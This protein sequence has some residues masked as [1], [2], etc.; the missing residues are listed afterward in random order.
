MDEIINPPTLDAGLKHAL[1]E[2]ISI[3][4]NRPIWVR[5][6]PISSTS[7][8][9]VGVRVGT[10]TPS[11]EENQ[12]I[13][14]A[15]MQDAPDAVTEF[16]KAAITLVNISIPPDVI[17]IFISTPTPVTMMMVFQGTEWNAVFSSIT[18]A[19]IRQTE[20]VNATRPES[21]PRAMMQIII[22]TSPPRATHCFGDS[23]SISRRTVPVFFVL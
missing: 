16:V 19:A 22:T 12:D 21:S 2:P 7:S 4:L 15:V 9:T 6:P 5:L 3:A 17:T 8:P 1:L 20:T 14:P 18:P 23:G 10:T 13:T 11:V